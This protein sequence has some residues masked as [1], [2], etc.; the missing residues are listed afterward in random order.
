MV[1]LELHRLDLRYADLRTRDRDREARLAAEI[2]RDDQR[3][4][5]LVVESGSQ[6]VL[7]DG[8]ARVNALRK[9][10]RDTV[11]AV[12][13]AIGEAEALV[14]R[15]R[16]SA[17]S[18]TSA[19]EDG[20]L[21]RELVETHG[22]SQQEVG[23]ELRRSTSWVSR[24][25]AL[26][27]VLPDSVQAAVRKGIVSAN[28]AEKHLVVLARANRRHCERLIE[29]LGA[30]RLTVRDAQKLVVAWKAGDSTARERIVERP[31]LFLKTA[32]PDVEGDPL[33]GEDVVLLEALEALAGNC[34]RARKHIRAGA[35]GRLVHRREALLRAW[36]ESSLAFD[37]LAALMREEGVDAGRADSV[38][39]PS[40]AG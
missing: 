16:L 21:V 7:I 26:V 31:L 35:I 2:A 33:D 6:L 15:H 27:R 38:R 39:D 14:L 19:I 4:P 3:S 12:L 40:P 30:H 23:I 37:G 5:V 8:F 24:R 25:L 13:L 9:L 34:R 1:D 10:G 36:S 18:R 20:W 29:Q 22:K 11:R 17:A 28:A 32:E